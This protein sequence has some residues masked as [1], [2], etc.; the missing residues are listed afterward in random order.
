MHHRLKKR[1]SLDSEV[2]TTPYLFNKNNSLLSNNV[3]TFLSLVRMCFFK[4]VNCALLVG[5]NLF[6]EI[7]LFTDRSAIPHLL[8]ME[9]ILHLLGCI[10]LSNLVNNG[11]NYQPQLVIYIVFVSFPLRTA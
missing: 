3:P 5:R 9:E 1:S 2:Y 10:I 6:K 7:M 8:L 11:I 4:C